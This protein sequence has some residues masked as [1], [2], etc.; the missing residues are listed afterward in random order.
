MEHSM[1]ENGMENLVGKPCFE[2]RK[3]FDICNY[4]EGRKHLVYREVTVN[5]GAVLESALC[6][7]PQ[8]QTGKTLF[9]IGAG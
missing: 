6:T 7:T 8:I 3:H 9:G 2:H 1:F 4:A 5:T